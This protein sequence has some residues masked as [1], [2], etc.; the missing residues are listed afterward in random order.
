ML[1]SVEGDEVMIEKLQA[2]LAE[3][4]FDHVTISL[5]HDQDILFTFNDFGG[6]VEEARRA[7]WRASA[8]I[9]PTT[10]VC[11]GC[12]ESNAGFGVNLHCSYCRCCDY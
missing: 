8:L 12:F 7:V 1:C 5:G 11:W 4:G 6:Y 3:I 2:S 10:H 9:F